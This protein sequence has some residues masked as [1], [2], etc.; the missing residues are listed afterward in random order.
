MKAGMTSPYSRMFV[1][2]FLATLIFGA[3]AHGGHDHPDHCG[4]LDPSPR[5]LRLDAARMKALSVN[6]GRALLSAP[7]I[8]CIKI[9]TYVHIIFDSDGNGNLSDRSVSEQ[10][11]IL[12]SDFKLTPFQF[13]LKATQRIE[14]DEWFANPLEKEQE[15][16]EALHVG[17]SSTLNVYFGNLAAKDLLGFASFPSDYHVDPKLDGVVLTYDSIPGSAPPYDEG[18]TAV[19]EVGHWL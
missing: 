2:I 19:H 18:K 15:Y 4:T 5:K 12:N 14:N 6:T 17:D 13:E 9:P 8:Q 1:I 16:K 3:Q 11:Q 10:M 7:C